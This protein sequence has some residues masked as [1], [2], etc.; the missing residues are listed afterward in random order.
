[1]LNVAIEIPGRRTLAYLQTLAYLRMT[2]RFQA[3]FL[4]IHILY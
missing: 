1:M 3:R 4:Y 2:P